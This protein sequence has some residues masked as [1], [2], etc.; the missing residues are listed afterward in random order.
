MK[1]PAYPFRNVRTSNG[2]VLLAVLCLVATLSFVTITAITASQRHAEVQMTRLGQLRARQLAEMGV[3][4]AVHPQIKPGDPLL[5]REVSTIERF[6]VFLSTEE[7]RLNLNSLLTEERLPLLEAIF[8]SWGMLPA[9]AQ[10]V[11]A[12]LMDWVDP[13]DLKRRPDSAERLDYEQSGLTGLPLNRP[14]LSLDE[15]DL[16]PRMADIMQLRPDWRSFFTLRGSGHL[17]VNTASAE[18][19]VALTGAPEANARLLVETRNG[20][21]GIPQTQD[22]AVLTDVEQAMTELG[23]QGDT[24]TLIRPLLTLAG[25]TLR[26]ESVGAAGD[27]LCG[28]AVIVLKGNGKAGIAEWGEFPVSTTSTL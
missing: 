27:H 20:P 16:V 2:S 12:T 5:H 23:I 7:S 26:I 3:A 10:S 21:D 28:L 19:L 24:A 1:L 9:D 17:D 8:T 6:D 18:A 22:D 15:V 25:Q 14:F 4:V 11:A 13:D